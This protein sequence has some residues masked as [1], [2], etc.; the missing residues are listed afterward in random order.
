MGANKAI[1]L[2]LAVS[3]PVA[4]QTA[5][6]KHPPK[7]A[8]QSQAAAL[9]R[10]AE[11]AIDKQDYAAAEPKLQQ[12][13]AADPKDYQ[14]WFD[15]G[16]V[17][18][19]TGRKPQAIQAYRRSVELK[20]DVFE[21]NLNLGVLLAAAGDP[22]AAKYLRA[23][24]GLKPRLSKPEEGQARAWIALGMYL[25]DRQPDEAI[26]A[27]AAASQ[28]APN[29]PVP[30]LEI[31]LLQEKKGNLEAAEQAFLDTV[32]RD[33]NSA[34][35][36][37]DLAN[38]YTR[39]K[40]LPAAAAALR[41]YLRLRPDD[42]NAHLQLGRVLRELGYPGDARPEFEAAARLAPADAAV[43]RELAASDALDNHL[44]E[45]EGRY[46]ELVKLQPDDPELR[47][48]LGAVLL[49][50]KNFAQAEEQFLQA[51]RLKPDL[52]DA[53]GELAV[54]AAENKHY[55]LAIRALDQRA[56]YLPEGPGTHFLRA[57]SY[58]N[59]RAYPQ[60]ADSY[61]KFLELSAGKYPDQEWQARHRLIAIEPKGKKK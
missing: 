20:P 24:T 56:R 10:E 61:H 4:A 30:Q 13:T 39:A 5:G 45:A 8:A 58:D 48:A 53:Y 51:V 9:V 59:L 6:K 11:S 27:F 42:V 14:A 7:P 2:L 55:E 18:S 41:S 19:S 52:A 15:L 36:F 34:A 33:P 46:R 35:G 1:L 44:P 31:G 3:L 40:R 29:D 12:A 23:A 50:Q 54:A 25:E 60:A 28:L 17:Y 43:L 16:F 26:R 57:T 37:A 49:K 47:Y 38:L 32:K 22:G 21:S